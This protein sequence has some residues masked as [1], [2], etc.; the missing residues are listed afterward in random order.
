MTC[1]TPCENCDRKGLPILFTRYAAAYSS[2]VEGMTQLASMKPGGQLQSQPGSVD[3]KT[4]RVFDEFSSKKFR[5]YFFH[6]A[7]ARQL[8]LLSAILSTRSDICH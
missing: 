6:L 3:L 5:C 1:A 4:A 8:F 2:R 7:L